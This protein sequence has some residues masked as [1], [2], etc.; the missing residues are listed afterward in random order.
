LGN[1]RTPATFDAL[2]EESRRA[3]AAESPLNRWGFP[4]EV[5]SAALF[6]ASDLSSFVTGQILVV[7]GGTL[8]R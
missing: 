3:L 8:R 2:D 6:L 7:D 4:E 1:I 5:G